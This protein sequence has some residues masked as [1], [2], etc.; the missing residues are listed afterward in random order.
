MPAISQ[1]FITGRLA[2][3]TVKST[4]GSFQGNVGFKAKDLGSSGDLVA[5]A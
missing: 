5:A 1:C 3:N 4:F 2:P